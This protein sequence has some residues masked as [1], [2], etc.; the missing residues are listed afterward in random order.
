MKDQK[1]LPLDS[2]FHY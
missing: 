1:I 2:I